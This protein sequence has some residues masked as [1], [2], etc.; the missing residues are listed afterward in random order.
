MFAYLYY[1][2]YAIYKYKWKDDVPGVYAICILSLLQGFNIL[3]ALFVAEII[4]KL[5]FEI[6][7]IYYG[8][9]IAALITLNYFRFNYLNNFN[10]LEKKWRDEPSKQKISLG[11]IVLV[12][13]L[14]SFLL[15]IYLADYV[16][17]IRWKQ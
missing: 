2:I 3:S 15:I 10:E 16:S 8:L 12:Y 17:G 5:D 4:T 13:I 7:K 14:M 6:N 11:V 9:L 1:R